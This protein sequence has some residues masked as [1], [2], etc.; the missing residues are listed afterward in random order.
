MTAGKVADALDLLTTEGA[1]TLAEFPYSMSACHRPPPD[2]L[3]TQA[4]RWR[5]RAWRAV[6]HEVPDDWRTPINLDD[7]KGQLAQGLPVIFTMPVPPD[8]FKKTGDAAYRHTPTASDTAFHAMA[9]VGYDDN[10]QAIR[11]INSWGPDWGDHGYAW[12][13][14]ATFK[15]MATEAY[16]IEPLGTPGGT[17]ISPLAQAVAARADA[18]GDPDTALA[19]LLSSPGCGQIVVGH[20]GGHR[21]ATGFLGSETDL[22]F[23]KSHALTID[24][25]LDWRVELRRWPQCEADLTLQKTVEA[26]PVRLAIGD[27]A[28]V[29]GRT[30]PAALHQ[31]QLF[32]IDVETTASLPFVHVIYLQADGSAVELYR[33]APPAGPDGRRRA[34]IGADGK[35]ATRFQVTAPYGDEMVIALAGTGPLFDDR[36]GSQVTERQFLTMLRTRLV[37]ARHDNTPI[38][39][40][41]VRIHTTD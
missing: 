20:E 29:P 10:R 31:G 26:S 28:G 13:D 23:L 22:T 3:K 16:V 14:Y 18:A 21:T 36:L 15:A 4:A 40:A 39:G 33:A 24:P 11:L 6:D 12:I 17:P 41:I 1:A 9:L 30:D 27:A 2:A 34:V 35:A 7:V 5:I 38:S 32:S 25:A 19:A 8:F 37:Q